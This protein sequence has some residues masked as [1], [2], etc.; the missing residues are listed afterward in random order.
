MLD[1]P[2]CDDRCHELARVVLPL[3]TV[4]SQRECERSEIVGGGVSLH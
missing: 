2:L 4:E 1:K 3:A